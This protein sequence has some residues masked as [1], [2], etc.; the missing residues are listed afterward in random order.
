MKGCKLNPL[1]MGLAFGVLWGVSICLMGLAA[2]FYAYG[3]DFVIAIGS[4][5][6]GYAPSIKGSLLGGLIGFVDAFITGFLIAWLYNRF[7]CC[8]CVCCDKGENAS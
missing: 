2:Y 7:N 6:P 5:Y 4:L 1:A 8:K 3:H